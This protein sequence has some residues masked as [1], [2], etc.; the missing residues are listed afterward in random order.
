MGKTITTIKIVTKQE[1]EML[2]WASITRNS[3]L[4]PMINVGVLL[5]MIKKLPK[6]IKTKYSKR[7]IC[8]NKTA[9]KILDTL[10]SITK[11]QNKHN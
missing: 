4:V 11:E 5:D 9:Q 6:V 1:E 7:Y 3:I 10:E 2:E 8:L